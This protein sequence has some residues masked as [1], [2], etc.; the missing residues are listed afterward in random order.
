MCPNP[1]GPCRALAYW[2]RLRGKGGIP[3]GQSTLLE[4]VTAHSPAEVPTS[5]M[6][7]AYIW[8]VPDKVSLGPGVSVDVVLQPGQ[9]L[10]FV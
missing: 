9:C 4:H 8:K 10:V 1:G 3:T 2:T 6:S 7:D 5:V